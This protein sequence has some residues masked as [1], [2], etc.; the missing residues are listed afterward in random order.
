M[1]LTPLFEN[2]E[3][4]AS[5][6]VLARD[7]SDPRNWPE[8]SAHPSN[9]TTW[10][11]SVDLAR[12][13]EDLC[14]LRRESVVAFCSETHWRVLLEIP[15]GDER[16][17]SQ[18]HQQ[19]LR[20]YLTGVSQKAVAYDRHRSVS[21]VCSKISG[22][23]TSIGLTGN[24]RRALV[25]ISAAANAADAAGGCAFLPGNAH[26]IRWR[27]RSWRAFSADRFDPFGPEIGRAE[28]AVGRLF[29]EGGTYAE[30]AR[31]RGV[32]VRTV[33]N[34]VGALFRKYRVSGR[35]ELV[36]HLVVRHIRGTH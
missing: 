23:L 33:A 4:R 32:S 18:E 1:T 35:A 30:I 7:A 31:Q 21:A 19:L 29:I 9:D 8:A 15:A 22:A 25:L 24:W 6:R 16:R 12:L 10:G 11:Q 2:P 17:L 36:Q 14:L 27:D 13:W 26:E 3:P 20:G 28:A 34:Q 5:A